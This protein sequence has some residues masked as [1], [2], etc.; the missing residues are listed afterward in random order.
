[1]SP[2]AKR[3]SVRPLKSSPSAPW[4]VRLIYEPMTIDR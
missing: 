3:A 2:A 4:V 1:M